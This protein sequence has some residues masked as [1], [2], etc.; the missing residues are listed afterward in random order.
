MNLFISARR[1]PA[2]GGRRRGERIF[3]HSFLS[4]L[5]GSNP[6]RAS[7]LGLL[8]RSAVVVTL[9]LVGGQAHA[10]QMLLNVSYDPTRELY[11]AIGRRLRG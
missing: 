2:G 1:T 8:S 11:K 9:S 6:S 7:L 3:G 10:D 5:S 4:N